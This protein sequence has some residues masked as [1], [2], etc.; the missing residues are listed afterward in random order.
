MNKQNYLSDEEFERVLGMNREQFAKLPKWK[1]TNLKKELK[2][3]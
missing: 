2:L 3:F 1:A